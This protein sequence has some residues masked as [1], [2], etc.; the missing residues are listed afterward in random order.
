MAWTY[1]SETVPIGAIDPASG[2]GADSEEKTDLFVDVIVPPN[3]AQWWPQYVWDMRQE[4]VRRIGM[5]SPN[6]ANLQ[7]TAVALDQ[8][9]IG[10]LTIT[11]VTT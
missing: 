1:T 5:L 10:Q 7:V 6:V 2:L 4:F 9:G 8:S 3:Q 11:L